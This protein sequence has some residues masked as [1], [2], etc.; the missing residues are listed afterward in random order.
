MIVEYATPSGFCNLNLLNCYKNISP[1]GFCAEFLIS[2]KNKKGGSMIV[3][4]P[5]RG[6]RTME[7]HKRNEVKSR[8]G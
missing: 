6:V 2:E 1:S 3:I 7:E 4:K 8:K 5:R